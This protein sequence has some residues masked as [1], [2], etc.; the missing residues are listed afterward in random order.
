MAN[1]ID[2]VIKAGELPPKLR[3]GIDDEARVVVS[4]QTLSENG[5]SETFEDGVLEAEQANEAAPFKPAA[6]VM[7]EL[8]AIANDKT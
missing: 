3:A 4:V 1:V 5:F 2:T 7:A 6:L 8:T